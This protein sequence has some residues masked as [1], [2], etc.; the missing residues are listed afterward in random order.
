M[1]R[2]LILGLPTHAVT[3]S[4]QDRPKGIISL[5]S[6]TLAKSTHKPFCFAINVTTRTYLITVRIR[7]I[8]R[9]VALRLKRLPHDPI[10]PH[11]A[12]P[13]LRAPRR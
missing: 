9:G 10:I 13:R 8:P 12:S 7:C 11:I 3:H 1:L 2:I 4:L 6:P 5:K